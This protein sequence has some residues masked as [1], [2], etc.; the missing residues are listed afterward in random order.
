MGYATNR[1]AN[2]KPMNGPW[3]R[4]GR[5]PLNTTPTT[6]TIKPTNLDFAS[7]AF[8]STWTQLGTLRRSPLKDL[9]LGMI[10]IKKLLCL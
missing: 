7:G 8:G 9:N 6:E 4:V 2:I 3:I 10:G 1:P 5:V